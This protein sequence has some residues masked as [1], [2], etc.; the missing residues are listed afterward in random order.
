MKLPCELVVL[1]I[2]PTARGEV[3]KELV[4]IHGFTQT[5]VAGAFGITSA[6]ISQYLKGLRGGNPL[7]ESS[8]FKEHF[9]GCIS[10]AA[11]RIAEGYDVMEELCVICNEVKTCGMLDDIYKNQGEDVPLAECI[12][13]PA[14]NIVV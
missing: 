12:E 8:P 10:R 5:R 7:V 1:E 3:A 4:T 2:L 13:C 14:D 11:D 9:Y 6:A